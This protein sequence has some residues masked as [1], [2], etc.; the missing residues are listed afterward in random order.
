MSEMPTF[1]VPARP[2]KGEM[3]F[4]AGDQI[5]MLINGRPVCA[6]RLMAVFDKTANS[7]REFTVVVA[8]PEA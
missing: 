4:V 5:V 3:P 2:A 7:V 8:Q 6:G 1:P